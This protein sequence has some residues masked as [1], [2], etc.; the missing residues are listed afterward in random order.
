LGII[1][2]EEGETKRGDSHLFTQSVGDLHTKTI[3]EPA[4]RLRFWR[5]AYYFRTGATR[6]RKEKMPS[7]TILNESRDL[8]N[9]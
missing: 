4:L 9:A 3:K 1:K 7:Q 8:Q 2:V 5:Q 6:K